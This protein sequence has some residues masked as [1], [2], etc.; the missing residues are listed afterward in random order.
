MKN[1]HTIHLE[2]WGHIYSILEEAITFKNKMNVTTKF[3]FN[4]VEVILCKS[5]YH[6]TVYMDDYIETICVSI[7]KLNKVYL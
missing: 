4:G 3:K 6:D 5:G 1:I 7:G 2:V